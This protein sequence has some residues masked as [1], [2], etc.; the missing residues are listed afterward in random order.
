MKMSKWLVMMLVMFAIM[1]S[2]MEC[3]GDGQGCDGGYTPPPPPPPID[4]PTVP[5]PAAVALVGLGT[6]AVGWLRRRRM[7]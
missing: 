1:C 2:G 5:A 6:A 4:N 3:Q 7:L